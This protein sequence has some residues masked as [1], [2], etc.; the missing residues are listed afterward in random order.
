MN[1]LARMG[2]IGEE[3]ALAGK[4]EE[5]WQRV[6]YKMNLIFKIK[7]VYYGASS[8]CPHRL[9]RSRTRAFRALGRGSNP[10]GDV[11]LC[12]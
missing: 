2:L 6:K 1:F 7:V 10:R 11:F 12:K 3:S 8:L 9:A 4:N 5:Q